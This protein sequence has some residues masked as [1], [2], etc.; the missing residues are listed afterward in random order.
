[1]PMQEFLEDAEQEVLLSEDADQ[2]AVR[3]GSAFLSVSEDDFNEF[4]E[5]RRSVS[6]LYRAVRVYLLSFLQKLTAKYD[7]K[8]ETIEKIEERQAEL[9][10]ALYGRFGGNINLEQ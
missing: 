10:T 9:K 7:E 6:N 8:G 5:E 1:M 4:I 3:M 2:H